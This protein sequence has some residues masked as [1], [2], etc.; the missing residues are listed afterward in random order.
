MKI[1]VTRMLALL[2]VLWGI[3]LRHAGACPV[4]Y[5]AS[6]SPTRGAMNM[7]IISLLGVTG[8]VLA[9]FAAMFLRMRRRA[10]TTLPE[11][12][13]SRVEEDGESGSHG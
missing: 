7:A 9:A 4:C 12:I 13:P 1:P 6:D 10:Q 8:G 5:G 3:S 11:Q 2:F